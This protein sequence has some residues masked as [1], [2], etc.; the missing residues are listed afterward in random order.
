MFIIVQTPFAD[1]RPLDAN[2]RGRLLKPDWNAD[3]PKGFIRGFG[4]I[5]PRNSSSIGLTGERSFADMDNAVRFPARIEYKLPDGGRAFSELSHGFAAYILMVRWQADLN[6]DFECLK[7]HYDAPLAILNDAE[8]DPS[9]VVKEVLQASVQINSVDG[10][11]ERSTLAKY[12]K[13]LALAYLAA[14][15]NNNAISEFPIAE[16]IEKSLLVG[17][18]FVHVRVPLGRKIVQKRDLAHY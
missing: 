6:L 4:K 5:S 10:S 11:S 13:S 8:I 7:H 1:F 15:T 3:I 9:K 18:P 16:E 12:A 2:G 17:D 14:T